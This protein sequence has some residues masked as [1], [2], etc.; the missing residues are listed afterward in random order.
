MNEHMRVGHG[1]PMIRQ[2]LAH[3]FSLDSQGFVVAFET[4]DLVALSA[5]FGR[6]RAGA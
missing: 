5:H 1:Y 2:A 6:P 4:E 3:S